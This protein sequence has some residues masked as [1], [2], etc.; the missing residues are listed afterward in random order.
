METNPESKIETAKVEVKISAPVVEIKDTHVQP[1]EP[2]PAAENKPEQSVPPNPAP[3]AEVMPQQRANPEPKPDKHKALVAAV[4]AMLEQ[5][6][7]G[8]TV[9]SN[10]D[11][12]YP[13]M[14]DV[15]NALSALKD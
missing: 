6:K 7:R 12:K 4:I 10:A 15:A 3:K 5:Y 2:T 13:G 8:H 9:K 11:Y 14:S 1:A